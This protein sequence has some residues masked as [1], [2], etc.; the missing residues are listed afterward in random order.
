M[1]ALKNFSVTVRTWSRRIKCD[2]LMLWFACRDSRTTG[3]LK[4]VGF[5]ALFHALLIG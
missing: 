2:G 3:W 1:H 4:L 5:M